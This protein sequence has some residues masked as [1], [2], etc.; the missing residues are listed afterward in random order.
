M[1]KNTYNPPED[2]DDLG[3]I[4]LIMFGVISILGT[5]ICIV[6]QLH[7]ADWLVN[8]VCTSLFFLLMNLSWEIIDVT[9]FFTIAVPLWNNKQNLLVTESLHFL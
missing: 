9:S 1:M 6:K 5:L 3:L 7:I 8:N 4:S 2:F